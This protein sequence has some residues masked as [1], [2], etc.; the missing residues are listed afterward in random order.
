MNLN[1]SPQFQKTVIILTLLLT[2]DIAISP[3]FWLLKSIILLI[4]YIY[5]YKLFSRGKPHK[6]ILALAYHGENWLCEDLNNQI[7]TFTHSKVLLNTGLFII[8]QLTKDN[9]KFNYVIFHDQ[10]TKQ[11][12]RKLM[13]VQKAKLSV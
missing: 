10:L 3:V 13:W 8:L 6:N 1:K 4:L 12:L 7:T 2:W 5:A 11:I 9:K